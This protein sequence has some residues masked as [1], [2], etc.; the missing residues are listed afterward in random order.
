MALCDFTFS[1]FWI[2][3]VNLQHEILGT[4]IVG[5]R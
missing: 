3:V 4:V 2:V 1:E 5:Q